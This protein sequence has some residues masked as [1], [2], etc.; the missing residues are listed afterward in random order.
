MLI[1]SQNTKCHYKMYKAGRKWM[2]C[3]I[4]LASLTMAGFMGG[5]TAHADAPTVT[6]Q[7]QSAPAQPAV[8]E[9]KTTADQSG[10]TSASA[11][12][13]QSTVTNVAANSNTPAPDATP[14][15][16]TAQAGNQVTVD[17]S[18]FQQAFEVHGD[19]HFDNTTPGTVTLTDYTGGLQGSMTLKNK[20]S[21]NQSFDIKG[22]INLGAVDQHNGGTSGNN[23]NGGDGLAFGFHDANSDT[24]GDGGAG[25]GLA[26]IPDAIG[27]K[28]DTT[29]N[30]TLTNDAQPDPG[31]FSNGPRT[32]K[33]ND[34]GGGQAFGAF[35]QSTKDTGVSG[36]TPGVV[37]TTGV[38]SGLD[39]AQAIDAP[40]PSAA[41]KAK[42]TDP[43][44]WTGEFKDIEINYNPNFGGKVVDGKI[45]DAKKTLTVTYDNKK[46][47]KDITDWA[48]DK[49]DTAFFVSA[50]TAAN[51]NLQQFRLQ[52]FT[53]QPAATV[54]VKYYYSTDQNL[55]DHPT[56]PVNQGD[57]KEIPDFVGEVD[58][59]SG[60]YVGNAYLTWSQ[61]IKGYSFVRVLD[62]SLLE[63]GTLDK[64]GNNGAVNY[65][66]V[67]NG[68][69]GQKAIIRFWDK[70]TN[71]QLGQTVT[72]EGKNN[73]QANYSDQAAI[74]AYINDGYAYNPQDDDTL[75]GI[76][77]DNDNDKD[78]NYNVYLSHQLQTTPE[79]QTVTRTI[80]YVSA[81]NGTVLHAPT[82]ATLTFTRGATTDLVTKATTT[83]DWSVA[84]AFLKTPNPD[85]D[86]YYTTEQPVPALT[87]DLKQGMPTNDQLN[88]TVTYIKGQFKAQVG[89]PL[90]KPGTVPTTDPQVWTQ[91]K[92]GEP[93][94]KPGT[95]P[96]TDPQAWTKVELGVPLSK[97][98][99]VPTTDPQAWAKA[100]VAEPVYATGKLPDTD[101]QFREEVGPA[102]W[103]FPQ[104]RTQVPDNAPFVP[105]DSQA[106]TNVPGNVPVQPDTL[107]TTPTGDHVTGTPIKTTPI[108]DH[109]TDTDITTTTGADTATNT[110][111]GN[112]LAKTGSFVTA[113]ENAI[114]VPLDS[115]SA[116]TTQLTADHG[117]AVAQ[118]AESNHQQL[119][120]DANQ[121]T[122][123]LPQT[124]EQ[125]TSVWA[126]LGLSL[127]SVLSLFGFTKPK[128]RHEN[129]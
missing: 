121:A 71:Q 125:R 1:D 100:Q 55:I 54:D 70:N 63:Q 128:K 9:A 32:S 83:G 50:G 110:K 33:R 49:T 126:L 4:T 14:T 44:N 2:F 37:T 23:G 11:Q 38:T 117:Q 73:T 13:G 79:M 29:Y 108:G 91:V 93:L 86:G 129:N 27:W 120:T 26:K 62:G 102:V 111:T 51:L 98:G 46:W 3:G 99:T 61:S 124:S 94:S 12:S 107:V 72:L 103:T 16:Q 101:P 52:S 78:Q 22:Q 65:L 18:N 47:Q 20:I 39:S 84:Q 35:I 10:A 116:Q 106:R 31:D 28:A 64:A 105:N 69:F 34:W 24:V 109:G 82:V 68:N 75:T 40:A 80:N 8:T 30:W 114:A 123:K 5:S 7:A 127:I 115:Q 17:P 67:Q 42:S 57:L 118:P 19:A 21:L 87:V 90:S 112:G 60:A 66:Y 88:L 59:P 89:V 43:K 45:V 56:A 113:E 6:P 122:A 25:L 95:V 76:T 92:V 53:Y 81:A 41:D 97:P 104:V 48:A 74:D 85:I 77:Y 119:T 36:N 15:A 96:T 58:Y